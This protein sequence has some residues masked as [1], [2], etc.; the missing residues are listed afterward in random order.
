MASHLGHICKRWAADCLSQTSC[1]EGAGENLAP[2]AREFAKPQREARS[3]QS[4]SCLL[5]AAT[6]PSLHTT[7]S[8]GDHTAMTRNSSPHPRHTPW[9]RSPRWV[10]GP[11]I[12]R[13]RDHKRCSSST[14]AACREASDVRSFIC[15]AGSPHSARELCAKNYCAEGR[16]HVEGK[17]VANKRNK[18]HLPPRS[19][20]PIA[21]SV[22]FRRIQRPCLGQSI[23]LYPHRRPARSS[24]LEEEGSHR[25]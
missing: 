20:Y 17:F 7:H 3:V 24:S 10:R 16:G 12:P 5:C 13:T 14:F 25:R 19:L 6:R 11:G 21:Q 15:W 22:H 23:V 4:P 8:A 2:A 18:H 1:A 9:T